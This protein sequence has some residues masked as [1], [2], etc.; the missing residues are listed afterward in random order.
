[1][2]ISSSGAGSLA[3]IAPTQTGSQQEVVQVQSQQQK[4]E[5]ESSSETAE[6]SRPAPSNE[7]VGSVVDITV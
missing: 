4:T 7:R 6:A 2:E 1:M 5:L 3:Q